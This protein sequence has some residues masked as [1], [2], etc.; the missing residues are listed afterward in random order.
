MLQALWLGALDA[1]IVEKESTLL[2]L[3]LLSHEGEDIYIYI[4]ILV[5]DKNTSTLMASLL[6]A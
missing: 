6:M 2:D 1:Y 3:L 5:K 4:Y